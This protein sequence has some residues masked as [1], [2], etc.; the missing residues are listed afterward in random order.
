M[1]L[2]GPTHGNIVSERLS[3]VGPDGHYVF[4]AKLDRHREVARE[5]GGRAVADRSNP[6]GRGNDKLSAVI[7]SRRRSN[8]GFAGN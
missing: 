1:N 8:L 2:S 3:D 7:A 4:P 6:K 5:V